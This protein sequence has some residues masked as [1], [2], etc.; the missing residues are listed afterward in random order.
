MRIITIIIFVRKILLFLFTLIFYQ[1]F[2]FAEINEVNIYSARQEILMRE[3]INNFEKKEKIKVNI[4]FSKANQLI[5]KL[6][7]EG[8]Y[9]KAD[10]LLTVDVA[11]LLKAKNNGLFKRID[12]EILQKQIPSIYRDKD[13]HWFGL[14]LRARVFVYHEERVSEKELGGYL[15]LMDS[16]WKSR[17]LVRSSNNVYNQSLISAMIHNYGREKTKEFLINFTK[18]FARSPSGGDRDQIRAVVAGEGDLA[19]VNSY[20]FLKM[21]KDDKKGYLKK[22]KFYLPYDDTMKTHINISGAGIIKYSK[23]TKNAVRFLEYLISDEAQKIYAEKNLEY[24]I[25]DNLIIT[26]F[27]K[28]YNI[29][30][31]DDLN[32]NLIADNNKKALIMMGEAG[33]Q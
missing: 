33:W 24:P 23:N 25:K 27:L 8:K 4:I 16:N 32:L 10:I 14:S 2:C 20:Y 22:I 15:S 29:A 7:M 6:E 12:S 19:L 18:N 31:K 21:K 3:L 5:K 17:L 28:G 26:D 9:T 1:S 13:N 11:R 30:K